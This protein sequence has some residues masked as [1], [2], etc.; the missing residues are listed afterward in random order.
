[1]RPL[2]FRRPRSG[3]YATSLILA[4][5]VFTSAA[6]SAPRPVE[7]LPRPAKGSPAAF[8][9]AKAGPKKGSPC[10][11]Q[12]KF[13]VDPYL[14]LD[15]LGR[16]TGVRARLTY[17]SL[18]VGEPRDPKKVVPLGYLPK[19]EG[20]DI[21]HLLAQ[22]LGG[23]G[24]ELKNYVTMYLNPNRGKMSAFEVEVG[25]RLLACDILDYFV[26]AVYA[27]NDCDAT[28]KN[29]EGYPGVGRDC[30]PTQLRLRVYRLDKTDALPPVTIDNV[31]KTP[32]LVSLSPSSGTTVGGTTVTI[33]G[34]D[35]NGASEVMFGATRVPNFTY[36]NSKT[37]TATSPSNS[38]GVVDVQVTALSGTT[39][40]TTANRF[41][42]VD[43]ASGIP[44][45]SSI[46][47]SAG[48]TAG[49][50]RVTIRGVA[51]NSASS[52]MFG[53]S[54]ASFEIV[55]S[56]TIE[57]FSPSHGAEVVDV[58]VTTP[59]GTSSAVPEGRYTYVR[60]TPPVVIS[61]SPKTGSTAGGTS[62]TIT[63][64]TLDGASQVTFGTAVASSFVVKDSTTITAVS[65]SYATGAVDV[66]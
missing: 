33:T 53:T 10:G 51:F 13:T 18:G 39:P 5:A 45:V 40:V 35:L 14:P 64:T 38:A 47:P 30:L 32:G 60:P 4:L 28:L 54:A 3:R 25:K 41:T 55:S 9:A 37:I 49:G 20:H 26:D 43:P 22:S 6:V 23:A 34:T 61:L 16:G 7:A 62:V 56:T 65:P 11:K 44:A 58:R 24:K 36:I 48:T 42:Y 2:S 8:D 12:E 29:V 21:G 15:S 19:T 46:T 57:A 17:D 63:G 66:G 50:D 1:M 52:V 59:S 31:P 27:G